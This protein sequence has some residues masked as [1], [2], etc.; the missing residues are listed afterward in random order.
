M[1]VGTPEAWIIPTMPKIPLPIEA[2]G[3]GVGG[4]KKP[5][6]WAPNMEELDSSNPARFELMP[7][8]SC[9]FWKQD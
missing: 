1:M 9:A 8:E 6:R 4:G 2:F 7:T 3:D 5:I